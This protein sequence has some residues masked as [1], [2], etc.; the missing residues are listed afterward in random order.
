MLIKPLLGGF[1]VIGCYHEARVSAHFLDTFCKF[2]CLRCGIGPG[3]GYDR[4]PAGGVFNGDAYDLNV[5]VVGKSGSLSCS[6]A[7]Y[8]TIDTFIDLKVHVISQCL[9]IDLA[10]GK[11]CD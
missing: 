7:G 2:Q 5:F 6:P 1:V 11:R 10:A 3:S 4:D 9:G 8:E